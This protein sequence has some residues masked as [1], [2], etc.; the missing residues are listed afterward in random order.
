MS[1]LRTEIQFEIQDLITKF[2]T[3]SNLAIRNR[4]FDE[5]KFQFVRDEFKTK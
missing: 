4:T 5:I 3:E 1:N 2:R